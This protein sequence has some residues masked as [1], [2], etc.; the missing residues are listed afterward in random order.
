[1]PGNRNDNEEG[2]RN[3]LT[4]VIQPAAI[5]D[6][7]GVVD[8][9]LLAFKDYFLTLMGKR[10]VTE[11]YSAV[12]DY[13]GA[14]FLVARDSSGQVIGFISGFMDAGSFYAHYRHR[15]YKLALLAFAAVLRKP[16][17]LGRVMRNVSRVRHGVAHVPR[18]SREVELS[19]LGVL[20]DYQRFGIGGMLVDRFLENAGEAGSESVYLTTDAT[21]NQ[22]GNTFYKAHGFVLENT[23]GAVKRRLNV[24]RYVSGVET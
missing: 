5:A 4:V 20:P 22:G 8:V 3:G 10:F 9:H 14:I 2:M 16:V 7:A 24:Y 13:H 6:L 15:R 17:L 11:Y 1:M 19:S 18:N 23:I 12:I 21:G